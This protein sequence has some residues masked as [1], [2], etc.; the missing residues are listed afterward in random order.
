MRFLKSLLIKLYTLWVVIVFTTFM[1][2]LLPGILLPVLFG[3][4][5]GWMAYTFLK[6]W[7]WIFSVL[8]FIHYEIRG[9]ENIDL[10]RSYIYASNHTSYL[11]VPGLCLGIPTQFRPLAK[12]ELLKVPIFGIIVRVLTIIVDRSST[13][14]R[15]KSIETLKAMLKRGI[16]ILIFPEGTQN[17]T[18]MLL[19]PFFDGAFR[20]ALQTESPILPMVIIN[21]GNLMHPSHFSVRPG[22]I[23]VVFGKPMEVTGLNGAEDLYKLKAETRKIMLDLLKNNK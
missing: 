4:K 14:S 6:I 9:R 18:E 20:I 8:T 22:K 17:R 1:I 16:S 21:A 15:R 12:K 3:Q 10:S 13:E 23:K 11:D 2:I 5:Q 7:S 19:Q